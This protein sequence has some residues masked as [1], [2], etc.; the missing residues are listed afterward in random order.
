MDNNRK[1]KQHYNKC[2]KE[3]LRI[4]ENIKYKVLKIAPGA[5]EVFKWGMP[6]FEYEGRYLIG[7]NA[8]KNHIA[9][10]PGSEPIKE[11]EKD[12]KKYSISKGTI[13]FSKAQ[14]LDEELLSKIIKLCLE[15]VKSDL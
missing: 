10:Y 11:L 12:L 13:R 6:V 3:D 5:N 8:A 4:L 9:I 1:L 14:N 15:R 2:S 7:I